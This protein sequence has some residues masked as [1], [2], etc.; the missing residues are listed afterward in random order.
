MLFHIQRDPF[1][2]TD[3]LES[4]NAE[5]LERLV[6]Y[7]TILGG[8][9][10]AAARDDA[11]D[12]LHEIRW[13]P[14]TAPRL[15]PAD[16][17]SERGGFWILADRGGVGEALRATLEAQGET[18][19][20]I[21]PGEAFQRLEPRR[22]Q[23]RP[24]RRED[25]QQLFQ[26]GLP[27]CRAIVH[28]F[29]LDAPSAREATLDSLRA[30]EALVSS[31]ALYLVRPWRGPASATPLASGWSRPAPSAWAITSSPSPSPRRRSGASAAP[32]CRSTR[33]ALRALRPRRRA[34]TARDRRPRR[35]AP[36]RRS[37]DQ[38]AARG[39]ARH[40][41]R[42]VRVAS[43]PRGARVELRPD[44]T[45]LITGG[46][47]GVGFETARWMVER[48]ARHLALVSRSGAADAVRADLDAMEAAG[49]AARVFKADVSKPEDV[50]GVLAEIDASMPP[51]GGVVHS[52]VVLE[53]GVLTRQTAASFRAVM[54]PKLDGAW[55]LH[56]LT[57]GRSLDFFVLYSSLVS[58]LGTPGQ[59]NYSAANA[60]VDA[61]AHQRRAEGCRG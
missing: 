55:N 34:I 39:Q 1:C 32:S 57:R 12:W 53:D 2:R 14:D 49:A 8:R 28:L 21:E 52:A 40:V 23:L 48:G 44:A 4:F 25:F 51:L 7:S 42:L 16:T 6:P 13:R 38:I 17:P 24:D 60:F 47:S 3:E 36:P 19:V 9:A 59:A 31:S 46:L 54:A 61:L 10:R 30:S 41:A 26:E 18:C 5:R 50:A 20:L 29:S 56:A 58:M 11:D 35:G 27:P 37:Q 43:R 15:A 45:Y 22:V 33:A